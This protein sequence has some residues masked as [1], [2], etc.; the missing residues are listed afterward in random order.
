MTTQFVGENS[1]LFLILE[2]KS[3]LKHVRGFVYE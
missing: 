3:N 2:A 1:L